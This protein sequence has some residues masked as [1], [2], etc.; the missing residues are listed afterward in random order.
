MRPEARQS[1]GMKRP[2]LVA[3]LWMYTAWTAGAFIDVALIHEPIG[4]LLGPTMA[5]IVGAVVVAMQ[6][7]QLARR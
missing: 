5:I 4:A 6:R 2:V 1:S 3:A 7:R